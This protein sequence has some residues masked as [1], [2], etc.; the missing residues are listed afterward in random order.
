M[1]EFMALNS[2]LIRFYQKLNNC[3]IPKLKFKALN[4]R[5]KIIY[6][7]EYHVQ[8]NDIN[9]ANFIFM[10]IFFGLFLISA[11]LLTKL[12]ML[13]IICVSFLLAL[14]V[15]YVL[16]QVI[17]K[18]ILKKENQMN[19]LLYIVKIYFSLIKKSHGDN[20]DHA[21]NFIKLIS[22]FKLPIS[23]DFRT[24]YNKVQLGDNPEILL[25]KVITPSIDFNLYIKELLLSDFNTN[26]R[27]NEN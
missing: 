12:S 8:E 5:Y 6:E 18:E 3:N 7:R 16:S 26:Y 23:R 22:E 1:G 27:L 13:L 9:K 19:A 24:M 14:I 20:A 25:S 10:I 11:S 2:I 4:D 21:I 15:S 17:I